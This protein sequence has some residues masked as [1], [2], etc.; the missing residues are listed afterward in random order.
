MPEYHNPDTGEV[1]EEGEQSP[2]PVALSIDAARKMIAER[3][4]TGID[5]DDPLLMMVTLHEGF[6]VDYQAMLERHNGAL[7]KV[8]GEAIKGLTDEALANHLEKQV[9]LADRIEQEF[10]GQYKKARWLSIISGVSALICVAALTI[11]ILK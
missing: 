11:L 2:L 1:M 10:L 3:H 4:G 5:E 6:I 8:I 7:T 9:R